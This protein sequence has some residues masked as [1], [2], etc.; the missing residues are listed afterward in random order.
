MCISKSV[1]GPHSIL[2]IHMPKE[3]KFRNSNFLN[4]QV[5]LEEVWIVTLHVLIYS[6]QSPFMLMNLLFFT[7]KCLISLDF[8]IY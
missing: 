1:V 6:I 5:S 8:N 4:L 3:V 2:Q 7:S